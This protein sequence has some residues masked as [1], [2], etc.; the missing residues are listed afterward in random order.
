MGVRWWDGAGRGVGE[1]EEVREYW[2]PH[3]CCCCSGSSGFLKHWFCKRT[4][5]R[6]ADPDPG[7]E[8]VNRAMLSGSIKTLGYQ[9]PNR[10]I[11]SGPRSLKDQIGLFSKLNSIGLILMDCTSI[12][13]IFFFFFC[14]IVFFFIMVKFNLNS[15][16]SIFHRIEDTQS[17]IVIKSF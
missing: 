5:I 8:T 14:S 10:R 17:Q 16:R 3:C 7:H 12:G 1:D 9:K 6:R 11:E 2:A 4:W 13:K 15:S